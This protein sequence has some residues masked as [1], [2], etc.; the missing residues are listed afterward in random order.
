MDRRSPH[1]SV[2]IEMPAGGSG[3]QIMEKSES[4]NEKYPGNRG[5]WGIPFPVF[6][7]T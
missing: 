4:E 5:E 2:Q 3:R 6:I 7:V 1:E